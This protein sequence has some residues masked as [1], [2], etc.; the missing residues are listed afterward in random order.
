MF[1]ATYIKKC[2]KAKSEIEL[3]RGFEPYYSELY[4]DDKFPFEKGDY[5]YCE[6]TAAEDEVKEVERTE[7]D[8]L[9]AREV[10]NPYRI[11]VC[12]WIPTADHLRQGLKIYQHSLGDTSDWDE[13]R[14]LDKYMSKEGGKRWDE[15]KGDWV[16]IEE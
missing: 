4:T 13:E 7:G 15:E 11:S 1:S 16:R 8:F 3:L 12:I 14:I 5:F 2:I 6:A 9:Y 10:S